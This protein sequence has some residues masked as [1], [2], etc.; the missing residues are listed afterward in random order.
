ML[1]C[2]E[3]KSIHYFQQL[4]ST[5]SRRFHVDVIF[6]DGVLDSGLIQNTGDGVVPG[7]LPDR[8]IR[9]Y[10]GNIGHCHEVADSVPFATIADG[11]HQ[12][13]RWMYRFA[14]TVLVGFV[15]VCTSRDSLT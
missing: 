1:F 9:T 3:R 8:S 15:Q 4:A 7:S 10:N 5:V 13:A 11:I 14:L 2:L 6:N 12:P